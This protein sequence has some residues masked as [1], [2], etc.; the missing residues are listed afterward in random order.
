MIFQQAVIFPSW[1][2]FAISGA[3]MGFAV[4]VEILNIR[5]S[6]KRAKPLKM[7]DPYHEAGEPIAGAAD[8]AESHDD[9]ETDGTE[10]GDAAAEDA[11]DRD[12]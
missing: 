1:E 5:R 2:V 12:G 9:A 6:S 8:D 3:A 10:P 11:T 7:H 4:F